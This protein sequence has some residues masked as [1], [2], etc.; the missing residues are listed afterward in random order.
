M[1]VLL[2]FYPGEQIKAA[3]EQE[4]L[5]F[6]TKEKSPVYDNSTGKLVKIADV[7]AGQTFK[8]IRDYGNWH[9]ISIGERKGYIHEKST[10]FTQSIDLTLFK[11]V[12]SVGKLKLKADAKVYDNR[13][14]KLIQFAT[15][16]KGQTIEFTD[17][18]G[19]WYGVLIGGRKGYIH[20]KFASEID[21]TVRI[22]F[23]GDAMMDWSVKS[24][25]AK[26]GPDYPFLHVKKELSSSDLG[27]VNLETAVTTSATKHPNKQYNFKSD[28][29]SLSG[30]KNAGFQ[31]VSLA[32]NHTL[33][34]QVG[35]LR[36]TLSYLKKYKL[37]Y[38]GGGINS[39]EAY[40][41][42]SYKIK[43]KTI[44]ILAFSR[45]LPEYSWVATSS[46]PG[47]ANGYDLSLINRS[48]K[49]EKQSA[50]YVFVYIHWGVETNRKPEAFQRQWAKA[51][52]DSG[53]DGVIGSHPHV[54]QGFEVYKNKPIAYSLGNF[55]FPDYVKGDKA[56]TAL[57]HL[58][59]KNKE[60]E[61]SVTPYKIYKDQ[62]LP[63]TN[64][65]K[66]DVWGELEKISYSN[67][68][69]INGKITF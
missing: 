42:K 26:K 31:L 36:D 38:M 30:L 4:G 1:L 69:I 54:L 7:S 17:D 14:K 16:S 22:T 41:A 49:K 67:I 27:I 11:E 53:A 12:E 24:T 28:P 2:V 63:L 18:L 59:I 55:L 68:K 39:T 29:A 8:R 40:A 34:Y 50:D 25:I 9:E 21:E 56:Q 51:M 45:V 19:S 35:G 65:Q 10:N 47:L 6:I 23:A 57:L 61:M 58:D 64:E 60:I 33:D 5:Y 46:K 15:L 48:I 43:E 13:T 32:N 66:Q 20:E 62:I 52:I 37:D 44:K 3:S